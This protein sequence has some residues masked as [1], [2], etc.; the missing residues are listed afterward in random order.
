MK[1]SQSENILNWYPFSKTD[2]ILEIGKTSEELTNLFNKNAKEVITIENLKDDKLIEETLKNKFDVITLIGIQENWNQV[3][4]N[5]LSLEELLKKLMSFL[6]SE[7]KILLALDNKFGLRLFA[8]NP[9]KI[10]NNKFETLIGYNNQPQKIETFTKSKLDKIF[11]NLGFNAR[12]YYPL[13]DYKMPNVIFS[14]D[15]LPKYNSID[16]YNPYFLENS[17]ILFNEIDVFREILKTDSHMF[18]FFTNS[19][20]IELTN[21]KCNKKYKYISFNNLRKEEYRL[22]TKIAD[23]YVEKQIINDK[24]KKHYQNI[25]NNLNVLK[26]NNIKTV[27]YIEEETIKSKYIEQKY[28]LNNV[29]TEKLEQEKADEFYEI[30]EKYI[31]IIKTNSYKETDYSKTVFGKYNLDIENKEILENLHFL[32]NGLWDMTFKNCFYID[33]EFY[34]F[35]QEWNECNLPAEYILYHSIY[36]TISL[37]R[38]IKIE[39]LFEKYGISQYIEIFKKLD[40]KLQEKIRDKETWEFYN[41]NHY[42]NIDDTKQEIENLNIRFNAQSASMEN[43]KKEIENLKKQN[44]NLQT[45]LNK[46]FPRRLKIRFRKCFP[47]KE[48]N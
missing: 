47:R 16:K 23:N 11:K 30:L 22:I 6:K 7:G 48:E 40:D 31:E 44:I 5:D 8:G 37:R 4:G 15:E 25:K 32:K 2:V 24:S 10:L 36:Y 9:E 43:M 34:F 1:I 19:F 12:F 41:Q 27:D 45:E 26:E 28:L 38:F 42:I 21:G 20:L 3:I 14:Q 13:P 17:D 29:L 35:D 33:G 18:E 46:T 39:D